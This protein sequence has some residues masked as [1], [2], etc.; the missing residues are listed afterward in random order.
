MPVQELN[1]LWVKAGPYGTAERS[2]RSQRL[3]GS[4]PARSARCLISD[5]AG[6]IY[7][8][9]VNI[10]RSNV[11]WF[12]PAKLEEWGVTVPA[13]WDEFMTDDLPRPAGSWRDPDGHR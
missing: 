13:N 4:V 10:H 11:M 12:V 3:D 5:E 2:V 1:A 9:P 7:T 8:V 6:N